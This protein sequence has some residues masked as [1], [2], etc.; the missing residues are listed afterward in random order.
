MQTTKA[1]TVAP[2]RG[3]FR[4][5]RTALAAVGRFFVGG[6]AAAALIAAGAFIV[7]SRNAV[8]EATRNAQEIAAIDGHGIVEPALSDALL[9]GDPQAHR[10]FDD[11]V[12]N[13]ILTAR[14]VRVKLWTLGGRVVYS[15]AAALEGQVFPL[16]PDELST[17]RQ[18]RVVAQV[19]NL[20]KPENQNE[21]GFG[22][23]LEVYVPVHAPGGELLAFETYHD[24]SSVVDDQQR[25]WSTFFPV[26]VGGIVLLFAV[27]L[28]LAWRLASRL[29]ESRR[30]S[31]EHLQRALDASTS[32][33]RRI[34]RDLH[35]GVVQNLA[36]VAF[37]LSAAAD[38]PGAGAVA[39]ELREGALVA[40]QAAQELRSLIVDIA[41]PNLEG[42]RL[43]GAL[44]DL[45]APLDAA[46]VSTELSAAGLERLTAEEAAILYRGAQEA[47]RNAAAHSGAT[48]VA[49][50]ASA[51]EAEARVEVRDNGRGFTADEVFERQRGGHVGLAMLKSLVDDAGG[52]LTVRS[53]EGGSIIVVSLGRGG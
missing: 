52:T 48:Q 17:I 41:P 1:R 28:P 8:S 15:D 33:R 14:V 42:A 40:R 21:R 22:R 11:I 29:E 43:E 9:A 35:D 50:R 3:R 45:L 34:A 2:R 7:V 38:Q 20:S 53:E 12:R 24:Y 37:S 49:V 39:V 36:G 26:I 16:E 19:S 6:L 23:L 47:L 4:L 31:E 51:T 5:S 30:Q 10:A 46:G 44:A 13:R 25:I 18:G 27:Q 32:E